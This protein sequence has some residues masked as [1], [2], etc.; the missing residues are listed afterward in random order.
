[1]SELHAVLACMVLLMPQQCLGYRCLSRLCNQLWVAG[2]ELIACTVVCKRS[3][4]LHLLAVFTN[5]QA[6]HIFTLNYLPSMSSI[7][8]VA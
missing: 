3:V 5:H 6:A 7:D 2:Q 1:M 4:V 8:G